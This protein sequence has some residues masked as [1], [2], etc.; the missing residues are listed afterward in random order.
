MNKRIFSRTT[1][2]I[3]HNSLSS[4]TGNRCRIL[5]QF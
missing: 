5:F 1:L 2:E 4:E 3:L